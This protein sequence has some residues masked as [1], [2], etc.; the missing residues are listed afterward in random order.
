MRKQ[1][2]TSGSKRRLGNGQLPNER[3][4]DYARSGYAQPE[5]YQGADA[6]GATR[7]R[8]RTDDGYVETAPQRENSP[9]PSTSDTYSVAG[10][11]AR[12]SAMGKRRRRRHR[13]VGAI[14]ALAVVATL[15]A[16][17]A[18][19]FFGNINAML[20]SGLDSSLWSVLSKVN[21]GEPF[22]MLL[23]GTDESADRQDD[24]ELAGVFR[25]DSGSIPASSTEG[26]GPEKTI[27]S[28][29]A[30]KTAPFRSRSARSSIF[31]GLNTKSA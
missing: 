3:L 26:G 30:S 20:H 23:L 5:S 7:Y 1:S 21:A 19:G 16:G 15:I 14:A 8:N 6:F 25:S 24:E 18:L 11:R 28:C 10:S 2:K 31:A 22:Y 12:Y 4:S 9:T 13:I 17:S 29:S 27:F